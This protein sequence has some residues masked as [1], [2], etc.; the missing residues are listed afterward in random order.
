MLTKSFDRQLEAALKRESSATEEG[1]KL[2]TRYNATRNALVAEVFPNIKATEPNMTDHG[3]GHVLQVQENVLRLLSDDGVVK[4]TK[5][6]IK[7]IELYLL[8]M[9][10]LLHDAGMIDGRHDHHRRVDKLFNQCVPYPDTLRNERRLIVEAARA[11]TGIAP[12]GSTD[13]LKSI[14]RTDF[15]E[16]QEIRLRELAAI[17]RLA[18]ELAEGPGRTSSYLQGSGFYSTDSKVYHEYSSAVSVMIDRGGRRIG[19]AYDVEV[20][21]SNTGASH[22]SKLRTLL[23]YIYHRILKT[24]QERMYTRQY[25]DF[26]R[27]F[28]STEASFN[29]QCR[30]ESLDYKGLDPVILPGLVVP[31]KP[32]ST[33]CPEFFWKRSK[34]YEPKRLVSQLLSMCKEGPAP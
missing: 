30:G 17:L 5:G 20:R 9:M 6:G 23:E 28:E 13:T 12:D 2:L 3:Y 25:S 4:L 34:A 1:S 31:D 14:Q 19:L 33:E 27:P 32:E 21:E 22:E 8:G 16:G 29:F 15:I 11:H 10:I 18:D 26:L 7:P 24:D